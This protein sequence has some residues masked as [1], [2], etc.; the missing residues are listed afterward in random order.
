[1]DKVISYSND[2]IT[3]AW[4]PA[5][6]I[7]SKLCW[8]ELS[9]V[10]KPAERPWVKMDAATSEQIMKQIDKCPSG[11]LS[12]VKKQTEAI[13]EEIKQ[14]HIIEISP[15]GPLLAYGNVSIKHPDG[16]ITK[17]NKVTALCRCGQSANKPYCDGIQRWISGI[18]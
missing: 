14:E 13:R 6:C 5:S 11:A 12:Y 2:E 17:K 3:V 7:H 10:F 9:G 15:D 8:K 16:S 4:K 18:K 1:M